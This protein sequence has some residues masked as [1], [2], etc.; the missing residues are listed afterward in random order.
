MKVFLLRIVSIVFGLFGFL[1][2]IGTMM[3]IEMIPGEIGK[4]IGMMLFMAL[5]PLGIALLAHKQAQ[6][7]Q[8]DKNYRKYEAV[9]ISLAQKQN[10]VLTIADVAVKSD[11]TMKEAEEF[12]KE[13][14]LSGLFEM[15]SDDQ[16]R[17]VYT[18]RNA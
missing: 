10:G 15:D 5:L 17:I 12:L 3:N 7:I 1:M 16:G 9:I 18:L 13:M 8:K 4:W 14:Y 2:F 6:K 11:L